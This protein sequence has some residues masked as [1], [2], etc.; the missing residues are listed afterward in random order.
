MMPFIYLLVLIAWAILIVGFFV[1]DFP[2]TAIASIF[3]MVLGV[4]IAINGLQ[5]INNLGTQALAVIH[6]GL[7]FYVLVRGSFETYKNY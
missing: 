7:G 1:K 3:L 4:Y 6:I 5:G 2:T